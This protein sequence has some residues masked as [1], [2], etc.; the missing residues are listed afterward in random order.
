MKNRNYGLLLPVLVCLCL[1]SLTSAQVPT[2]P[3]PAKTLTAAEAESN[4][5]AQMRVLYTAEIAHLGLYR[6]YA[7]IPEMI[8]AGLIDKRF[9]GEVSGYVFEVRL[10]QEARSYVALAT[11]VGKAGRY[12]YSSTTDDVIRYIG[13]PAGTPIGEPIR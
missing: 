9:A 1:S 12:A 3:Q 2:A 7:T 13:G 6:N 11:P 8:T 10:L 5:V 4:A